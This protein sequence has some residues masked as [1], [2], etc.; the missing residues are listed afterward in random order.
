MTAMV[1][2]ED[3]ID[4]L[5]TH[6]EGCNQPHQYGPYDLGARLQESAFYMPLDESNDDMSGIEDLMCDPDAT[7]VDFFNRNRRLTAVTACSDGGYSART[8]FPVRKNSKMWKQIRPSYRATWTMVVESRDY[9][10]DGTLPLTSDIACY[11]GP[12]SGWNTPYNINA[13]HRRT[14][15]GYATILNGMSAILPTWWVAEIGYG[16]SQRV[17]LRTDSEGA[18][19]LFRMRDIPNGMSRR[20]SLKHWVREHVRRKPSLTPVRTHL[21]GATEF[22]WNGFNCKIIPSEI[23][24]A[25]SSADAAK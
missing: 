24:L 18:R 1:A 8:A 7:P 4:D 5:L 22:S 11:F 2:L 25:L 15:K 17:A 16:D 14:I 23:D 21:R 6:L 19:A 13:E 10:P 3:R 12:K 20:A 9:S